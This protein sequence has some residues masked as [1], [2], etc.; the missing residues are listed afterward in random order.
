MVFLRGHVAQAARRLARPGCRW[1]GD[2]LHSF[3]S[4]LLLGSTQPTIKWVPGWRRPSVGLAILLFPSVYI[5]MCTLISTSPVGLMG[6]PFTVV[7]LC[8]NVQLALMVS[9][10]IATV[11]HNVQFVDKWSFFVSLYKLSAPVRLLMF[12]LFACGKSETCA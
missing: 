6:I 4:R 2:F 8:E 7:F 3:V 10:H 1:G 12:Q 11:W 9:P 5:G